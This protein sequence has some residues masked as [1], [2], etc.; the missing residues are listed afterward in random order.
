MAARVKIEAL[1]PSRCHPFEPVSYPAC[2]A[3]T[4]SV[5]NQNI[6]LELPCLSV[7]YLS[8]GKPMIDM[9]ILSDKISGFPLKYRSTEV[10][11]LK[12]K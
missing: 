1:S 3:S 5:L 11:K 6:T 2:P 9:L 7:L 12:N 4:G 8:S 10:T